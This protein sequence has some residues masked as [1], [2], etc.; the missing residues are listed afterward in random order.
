[1]A[2]GSWEYVMGNFRKYR[3]DSGLTVS[4]V[5]AEHIDIYSGT[6]D[7]ES[8]LG[9][10]TGETAGWYNDETNFANHSNPWFIRGGYNG[11]GDIA[12]VFSIDSSTGGSYYQSCAFRVVLSTTGA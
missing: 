2:G 8:H 1:M 5:P 9:D 10:A 3:E 4:E 12:G 6:S 11:K 7:A